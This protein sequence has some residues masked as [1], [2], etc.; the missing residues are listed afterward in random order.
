MKPVLISKLS[1]VLSNFKTMQ[2]IQIWEV[3]CVCLVTQ[4][5]PKTWKWRKYQN[6]NNEL[7]SISEWLNIDKLY[8]NINKIKF[9]LFHYPQD[10]INYL[11]PKLAINSEPIERATK[12]NFFGLTIDGHLS[13]TSTYPKDYKQKISYHQ[14][15]VSTEK[16]SAN[17]YTEAYVHLSY[18]ADLR[19]CKKERFIQ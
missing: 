15:Y 1:K 14:N 8:L 4:H 13:W 19:N 17:S 12:C 16:V 7:N 18:S 10:N 9:M 3:I 11:T 5:L 2:M 6:I